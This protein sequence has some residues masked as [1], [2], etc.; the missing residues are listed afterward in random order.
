MAGGTIGAISAI[1][2]ILDGM[3]GVA[4]GW[5]TLVDAIHMTTRTVHAN[6]RPGQFE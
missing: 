5:D 3:T 2:F 6:M 4:G 1:V